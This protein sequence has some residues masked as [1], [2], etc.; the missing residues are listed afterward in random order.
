MFINTRKSHQ[1][2]HS[3]SKLL[4]REYEGQEKKLMMWWPPHSATVHEDSGSDSL[5]LTLSKV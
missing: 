1:I 5:V 4:M 3:I 2:A